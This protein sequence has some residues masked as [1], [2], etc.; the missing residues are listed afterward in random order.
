MHFGAM[1]SRLKAQGDEVN[2]VSL[3]VVADAGGYCRSSKQQTRRADAMSVL[4]GGTV[5]SHGPAYSG[6]C[7]RSR[8]DVAGAWELFRRSCQLRNR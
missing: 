5:G 2:V 1:P 4:P 8:K 3:D 7:A 6:Q